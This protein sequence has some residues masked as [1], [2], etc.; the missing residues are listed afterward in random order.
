[1]YAELSDLFY[2]AVLYDH[3]YIEPVRDDVI[4]QHSDILD[5][6][7]SCDEQKARELI[8]YHYNKLP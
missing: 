1:M 7:K 6:I 4:K 5:A 2:L 8:K 3:W